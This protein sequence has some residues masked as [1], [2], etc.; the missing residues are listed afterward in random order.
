MFDKEKFRKDLIDAIEPR[1][2]ANTPTAPDGSLKIIFAALF[3]VLLGW[4]A[5]DIWAAVHA[6]T[7][8]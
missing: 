7:N 6:I 1:T 5:A 8:P 2:A 4:V 3:I